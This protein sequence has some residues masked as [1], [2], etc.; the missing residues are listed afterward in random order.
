MKNSAIAALAVFVILVLAA[1]AGP[2]GPQGPEGPAGPRGPEGPQGPAGQQGPPGPAGAD[3]SFS[4]PTYIGDQTCSGC[5]LPIYENYMRSG[6]P[7][8]LTETADGKA[9]EFPFSNIN[10]PPD[11]YTWEDIAFV[12]GGY[13]WKALF[14]SAEGFILTDAPDQSG[15][16]DF[17][18]QFNLPNP[19][20]EKSAEWTGFQSGT[21]AL[22][23]DCGACHT[24][25]FNPTGRQAEDKPGIQ[26]AWAAPGVRC[27]ACHGPGSL[28]A[29]NP[30][31]FEMKIDRDK[32]A[33]QSCHTGYSGDPIL[34]SDGFID[35]A[36]GYNDLF[37]GKHAVLD[38]LTCHDPHTGV[39]QNRNSNQPATTT[40]CSQCH[41]DQSRI[42]N[43]EMHQALQLPCIECHMPRLIKVAAGD[44][45]KF[46]GDFRTHAVKINPTQISQ[47]SEDGTTILPEI[48]LDFACRHCH[49][50][51]FA[52]E[53]SD[54]DLLSAAS[55]YHSASSEP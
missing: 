2:Q 30:Q 35:H 43:V 8:I 20:L 33:C 3:A 53:K 45:E 19:L 16:R 51:G 22:A 42:Q 11:G 37:E 29:S 4:A 23:Y 1:C 46:Q 14:I 26:G 31:G 17:P 54:E 28:H 49:G 34:I 9:P 18:N 5:H 27:E 40:Q 25:G 24:T 50:G 44:A 13:N 32:E 41:L 12:I 48:G 15:N 47:F 36:Q 21:E 7:W 6:H 55:G 10:S 39:I 38:C 52:S